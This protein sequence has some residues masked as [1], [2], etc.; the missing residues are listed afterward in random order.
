LSEVSDVVPWLYG[1]ADQ[2]R[3]VARLAPRVVE[4]AEGGDGVARAIVERA[5]GELA[6][7]CM[8]AADALS[9]V[10]GPV[11]V[12]LAGG[13]LEHNAGYRRLLGER[14]AA[15]LPRAQVGSPAREA[16]HGAAFIALRDWEREKD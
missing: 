6:R 14:V 9:L 4:A 3:E 12:L 10:E 16:A 11:K 2:K 15:E 8:V 1:L 5:A 13:L 7:W